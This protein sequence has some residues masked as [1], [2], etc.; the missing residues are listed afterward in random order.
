MTIL[1][2]PASEIVVNDKIELDMG[3]GAHS[4]DE[5]CT[6]VEAN[7]GLSLFKNPVIRFKVRRPNGQMINVIDHFPQDVCSKVLP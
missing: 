4:L 1:N 7:P 2:V 6:V 5:V 3:Y